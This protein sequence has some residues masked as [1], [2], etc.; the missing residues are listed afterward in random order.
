MPNR[1]R[2]F[3]KL[4]IDEVGVARR[5]PVSPMSERNAGTAER[6]LCALELVDGMVAGGMGRLDALK[7]IGLAKSARYDWRKAHRRG[8]AKALK[9]TS[10]WP[11]SVRRR[12]WT[13]ADGRAV[14]KL[15]AEH[16]YMGKARLRK[17]LARDGLAL[18]VPT[19][20]RMLS[21]AIADGRI[22]PAS[23]C[24]G[25][26]KPKRRRRFDGAW[27]NRWKHGAKAQ[28]PRELVQV[29]HMTHLRREAEH[30]LH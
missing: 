1:L 24:E 11:R 19:V 17:M 7:A 28:A 12:R 13:D 6:R 26:P 5:G 29:D 16:P 10:T 20:G 25:R 2:G 14:L 15:R 22:K 27:A 9:A 21:K 23:F 8:G 30:L 18:S 3:D 4:R